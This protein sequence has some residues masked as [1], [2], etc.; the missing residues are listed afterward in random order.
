[1]SEADLREGL[2]AAVGD[3]PPLHF[4]PD[5]L[6]R[7]A[8]RARRRRA[9]VAVALA[10]LVL[11]G[12]ALS[13]PGVLDQRPGND[14]A[15]GPVLTI[16]SSPAPSEVPSP[17][18]PSLLSPS[19]PV[20]T[21]RPA[22]TAP[23]PG[24]IVPEGTAKRLEEYLAGRFTEVVQGVDVMEVDFTRAYKQDRDGYLTGVVR[25]MDRVAPTA[26]VVQLSTPAVRPTREEFCAEVECGKPL[27]QVDGGHVETATVT[28]PEPEATTRTVAHFRADGSVVLVS[29]Y[30]HDPTTSAYARPEVAVTLDQLVRLA[31]D[32][33]LTVR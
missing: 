12:T 31:V 19:G 14:A 1:M 21:T 10:T 18:P 32:P 7:R 22:S 8:E 15:R 13:L 3:E 2:R 27:P 25:F 26:V 6:I 9:L 4:D 20:R 16:T 33:M 5:E 30:N 11:T 29:G 24:L 28:G 17:P 23:A